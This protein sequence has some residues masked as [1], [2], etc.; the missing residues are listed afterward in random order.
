MKEG[1]GSE[2]RGSRRASILCHEDDFKVHHLMGAKRRERGGKRI[3]RKQVSLEAVRCEAGSIRVGSGRGMRRGVKTK[4]GYRVC[5]E[6]VPGIGV[7]DRK[8]PGMILRLLET[9]SN[10]QHRAQAVIP[11]RSLWCLLGAGPYVHPSSPVSP[12]WPLQF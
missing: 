2:A 6:S 5:R 1:F 11:S 12:P 8:G 3:K 10:K 4:T 9:H 7:L